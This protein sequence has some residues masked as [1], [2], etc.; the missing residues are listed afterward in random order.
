M[1]ATDI[2]ATKTGRIFNFSAGPSTLPIEVLEQAQRDLLNYDGSGMSVMEMSH[3]SAP[4]E[5]IINRAEADLR[6]LLAIPD[7]YSVLFLQGG[8]SLQFS[9]IAMNFLAEGQEAGYIVTGAWGE[10]ALESAQLEGSAKEVHSQKEGGYKKAPSWAEIPD[11]RGLAY[12]HCTSNETIQGVEFSSDPSPLGAPIICDMSSDI[13]SRPVHVSAYDLIYAGAQK[14]MGPAGLVVVIA[15]KSFL[16]GAKSG[17]GPMLDYKV[18][19]KNK[20]LYN[21]PPCWS[22]YVTGL[23]FQHLLSTGGISGAEARNRAKAKVIYDAIDQSDGF[24]KG[25]AEV[26]S[27]SLMNITFTLPSDELTSQFIKACDQTQ[28]DG[29]KG[30][31]SVGGCRA[32]VYNAFPREGCDRLAE[33]MADFRKSH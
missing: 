16:A 23:V 17:L 20:S 32:S 26:G 4:F 25:H 5:S 29:L 7:D 8:A 15:K 3:R 19:D 28:L 10:K 2:S 18:Q 27:R 21:T 22:I 33:L 24:F 11:C 1:S 9:M 6:A 12:V 13:L 30:H 14:N 31:R